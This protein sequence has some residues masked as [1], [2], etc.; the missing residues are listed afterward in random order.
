M[1]STPQIFFNLAMGRGHNSNV[2][3]RIVKL[4]AE[5][6]PSPDPVEGCRRGEPEALRAV[7]VAHAPYVE[8]LLIRVIGPMVDIE[9]VLQATFVAA[10]AAFPRF[11]GEATVRTWL[12]RIA[13]RTAQAR[14]RRAEHRLRGAVPDL[15]AVG[16]SGSD[17][18]STER[19][20]DAERQLGRVY[21]HLD[22][23]APKKRIAFILHVFEGH[24]M[25]E[26]AALTGASLSATKSRV[27]WARRELL[28]RAARDPVLAE[29]VEE[30][31]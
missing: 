3:A 14:L 1:G 20:I 23:I 25:E 31:T 2:A 12:A 11:R 10:I 19:R 16:D 30:L 26:V 9:D 27:L 22:R 6:S 29:L 4:R 21:A 17:A 8:R 18:T 15:E 24:P 28:K 13:I 7:F 5:S